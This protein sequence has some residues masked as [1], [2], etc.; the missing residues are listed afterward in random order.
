MYFYYNELNAEIAQSLLEMDE[1]IVSIAYN[2][3]EAVKLYEEKEEFFF[4]CILMDIRMPVM[5]G[6]EA[7]RKIRTSGKADAR[8]IPIIA[9][10]ANAFDED[11]Q[12]SIEC[13]MNGHVAKPINIDML[14][15][16]LYKV[17]K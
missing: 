15:E 10:S 5:N 11:T 7:T 14:H 13:G 4:D 6:M 8:S 1:C 12:K 16:A 3:A 17:L 2:G 9:L